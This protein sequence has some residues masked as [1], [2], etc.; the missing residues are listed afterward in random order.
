MPVSAPPNAPCGVRCTAMKYSNRSGPWRRS[1]AKRCRL[2]SHDALDVGEVAGAPGRCRVGGRRRA[3]PVVTVGRLHP[4][5]APRK[6]RPMADERK[7]PTSGWQDE[8]LVLSRY[9]A[10]RWARIYPSVTVCLGAQQYRGCGGRINCSS[11]NPDV[12]IRDLPT[13]SSANG[14]SCG[15]AEVRR[16]IWHR[17]AIATKSASV[18]SASI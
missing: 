10:P 9:G 16:R 2:T 11:V 15:D 8:M 14:T 1:Q 18:R 4:G 6:V 12:R 13:A 5:V 3:R 7:S 17:V